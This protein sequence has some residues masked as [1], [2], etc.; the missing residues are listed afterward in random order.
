MSKQIAVL[1]GDGVGPEVVAEAIKVLEAAASAFD[2]QFTF[3]EGLLGG[4]AI[5][6]TGSALPDETVELCKSSA[7]VLLGAVG[8]PKWD[9]P[10]AAVRPEQG[11]LGIRKALGLFANLRPVRVHPALADAGPLRRELVEGIDMLVV[12][13]LTG[14]I[15]FGKRA[16]EP[17]PS[18]EQAYDTM[19]YNTAEVER[20][21]R[22]A[23]QWAVQR[24][25]RVTSVDKANVLEVSRL[26]RRTAD[27]VLANEF[28]NLKREHIL[29]DA[30]AMYLIQS[31]ARFD[32]VVTGNMFGDIL[33]DEA[34]VLA[35]SMG[36]LP[37][38]SL[39]ADGPGL[40]EP[41]HGSAPD[42]A[43][44]GIANPIGMILSAAMMCRDSLAWPAGAELIES[45]VDQV[46]A[47]GARTIDIAR[48][49]APSIGTREMGDAIA[50]VVKSLAPSFASA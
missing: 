39:G 34:S 40:Y 15:Y 31:P 18:G 1:P 4:C 16:C 29:V 24:N 14:G 5:D 36:L 3:R 30:A 47:E 45:A 42:I 13:E 32:V 35:G 41:I 38:A 26:W 27:K 44:K 8:G 7:A 20:V 2:Q 23:A 22:L 21:V 25:G 43:G 11:L 17:H 46:I 19:I 37:S 33:T 10:Q 49:G 50:N 6:A 12:R 9:N 28:P 48:P